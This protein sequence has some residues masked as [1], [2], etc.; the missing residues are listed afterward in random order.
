MKFNSSTLSAAIFAVLAFASHASAA[1]AFR[2]TE[3]NVYE[4]TH[5]WPNVKSSQALGAKLSRDE[6]KPLSPALQLYGKCIEYCYETARYTVLREGTWSGEK[7]PVACQEE[8]NYLERSTE[9]WRT[10]FALEAQDCERAASN[11]VAVHPRGAV[12]LPGH[13]K[14]LG[15]A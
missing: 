8:P 7:C 5:P 6:P 2:D 12:S 13:L 9:T 15:C 1:N 11:F 3:E 10:L 4:N 14:D